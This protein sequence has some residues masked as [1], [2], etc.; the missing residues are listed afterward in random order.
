MAGC[1]TQSN[2]GGLL[3]DSIKSLPNFHLSDSTQTVIVIADNSCI[4]CNQHLAK[5]VTRFLS[6]PRVTYVIA[7]HA[8]RIDL[9]NF[10][11]S[12]RQNVYW[13]R[14]FELQNKTGLTTSSVLF[15]KN[16]HVDTLIEINAQELEGQTN[17]I[18]K[19]MGNPVADVL[20]LQES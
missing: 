6:D 15:L 14:K 12:V 19:R 4:P 16:D 7:A 2:K 1:H 18:M 3:L 20:P 8:D 5:L 9:E 17:Y 13:D 11:D 10:M